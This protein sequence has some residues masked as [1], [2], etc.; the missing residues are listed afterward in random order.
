LKSAGNLAKFLLAA[1]KNKKAL[2]DLGSKQCF[3][4]LDLPFHSTIP[5]G[6][7]AISWFAVIIARISISERE[8]HPLSFNSPQTAD[9][10]Q[11]PEGRSSFRR[12]GLE[13]EERP[14]GGGVGRN[15]LK[16]LALITPTLTPPDA[17]K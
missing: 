9:I 12:V 16:P 7:K 14:Q 6:L 17:V 11:I 4:G 13:T 15:A 5:N 1:P 10:Y 3:W 8:S 2:L